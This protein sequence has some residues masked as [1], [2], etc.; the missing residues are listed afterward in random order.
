MPFFVFEFPLYSPH[1]CIVP[2]YM[3]QLDN[4]LYYVHS[5]IQLQCGNTSYKC[6]FSPVGNGSLKGVKTVHSLSLFTLSRWTKL[7]IS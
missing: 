5:I 7:I 1:I 2:N 4:M 3:K 6:L